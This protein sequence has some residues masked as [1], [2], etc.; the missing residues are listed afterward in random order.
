MSNA[1]Q[2]EM[3]VEF[4][5]REITIKKLNL[6]KVAR[7]IGAVGDIPQEFLQGQGDVSNLPAIVMELLPKY[8]DLAAEILENQITGDELVE[9]DFDEVLNVVEAFLQ[10]NDI[11]RI[12]ERVGKVKAL[13]TGKKAPQQAIG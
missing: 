7:L 6:K 13:A 12:M 5:E 10:V 9:A 4:L 11:P 8:A 1:I 3:T 2:K